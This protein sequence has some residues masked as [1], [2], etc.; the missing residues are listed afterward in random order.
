MEYGLGYMI[1][2]SLYT[3]YS[4]YLR[5]TIGVYGLSV[6][7]KNMGFAVQVR[8]DRARLELG[9]GMLYFRYAGFPKIKSPTGGP[10]DKDYRFPLHGSFPKWRAGLI[11]DPDILQSSI[12]DSTN[13]QFLYNVVR[14]YLGCEA[15][16]I[17][18]HLIS[19]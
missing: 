16:P 11:I 6:E 8:A 9:G 1:I 19:I 7:E 10:Y 15:A 12:Q 4:I 17:Q 2:R 18:L 14:T 3:P 13:T 5:G